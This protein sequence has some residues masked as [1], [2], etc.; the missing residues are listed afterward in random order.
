MLLEFKLRTH[1]H[2]SGRHSEGIC[3][4]S[5]I[6]NSN[7][8]AVYGHVLDLIVFIGGNGQGDGLSLYDCTG[9]SA[10]TTPFSEGSIL[11]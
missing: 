11:I 8:T 10:V 1:G 2:I 3:A 9:L 4:V 7:S 6:C 5:V